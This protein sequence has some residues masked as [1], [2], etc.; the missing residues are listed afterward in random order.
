METKY[1]IEGV[2]DVKNIMILDINMEDIVQNVLFQEDL[3][4]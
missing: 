3:E 2:I 1:G 4:Q